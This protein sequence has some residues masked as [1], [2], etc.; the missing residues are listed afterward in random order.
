MI[1]GLI[2]KLG[3][4]PGTNSQAIAAVNRKNQQKSATNFPNCATTNLRGN[5]QLFR[6]E[7]QIAG[8]TVFFPTAVIAD[9]DNPLMAGN[10]GGADTFGMGKARQAI[11]GDTASLIVGLAAPEPE[12]EIHRFG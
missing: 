4:N 9:H 10:H 2:R 8:A 7:Q 1:A 5:L 6:R 11:N 12:L 3:S